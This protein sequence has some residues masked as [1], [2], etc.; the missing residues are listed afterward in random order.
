LAAVLRQGSP[1][2]EIVVHHDG[3]SRPLDRAA[4]DRLDVR[5]VEPA[6]PVAW[7]EI[8]HVEAVLWSLSWLLEHVQFEWMVLISGQDY[9]IK[10]IAKIEGR[11]HLADVDAFLETMPCPPPRGR[12]VDEFPLRYYFRWRRIPLWLGER[13]VRAKAARS[14]LVRVRWMPRSGAWLLGIRAL[15]DPFSQELTCYYGP[16]WFSLSRRAVETL[17]ERCRAHADLLRYYRHTLIPNESFVHTVL[18]NDHSL[19]L[20]GD[21]RRYTQWDQPHGTGPRVLRVDDIDA[22][23]DSGADFARKFDEEVDSRVLDEIDRRVHGRIA[24]PVHAGKGAR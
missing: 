13:A 2:A 21:V 18:G 15:N 14:S 5:L 22:I 3:T 24:R 17:L 7:G 9:P 6:L 8:S 10:P 1:S 20:S 23:L 19:R 12:L 11:L 4:L 16:D